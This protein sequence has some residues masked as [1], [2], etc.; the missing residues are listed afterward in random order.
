MQFG[1]ALDHPIHDGPHVCFIALERK[2]VFHPTEHRILVIARQ[3]GFG[4]EQ[5]LKCVNDFVGDQGVNLDARSSARAG[6][7]RMWGAVAVF[8]GP[9]NL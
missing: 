1:F 4:F 3:Q 7:V 6:S 2:K 5:S 8:F 9:V